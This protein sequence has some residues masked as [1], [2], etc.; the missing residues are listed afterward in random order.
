M[1]SW[2]TSCHLYSS[3]KLLHDWVSFSSALLSLCCLLLIY[4]STNFASFIVPLSIHLHTS[5]CAPLSTP[6][7]F[8]NAPTRTR[9]RQPD[10]PCQ[11]FRLLARTPAGLKMG[12]L[13]DWVISLPLTIIRLYCSGMTSVHKT[14]WQLSSFFFLSFFWINSRIV[15]LTL[16]YLVSVC[17]GAFCCF[18]VLMHS[19]EG[20][21]AFESS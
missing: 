12:V 14:Y 1:N 9:S 15:R 17:A 20:L 5:F 19:S 7:L 21:D 16:R 3:A 13:T 18:S 4:S 10:D 6:L 11:R 2:R 8:L